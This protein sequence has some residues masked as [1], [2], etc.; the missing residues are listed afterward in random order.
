MRS[1]GENVRD[2]D[3]YNCGGVSTTSP[4]PGA[5]EAKALLWHKLECDANFKK[6]SP[7]ARKGEI[8]FF[9]KMLE[10]SDLIRLN[11]NFKRAKLIKSINEY[12]R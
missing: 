5:L 11:V 12:L 1:E 3:G 6:F 4:A 9:I 7:Y 2:R 10:M 8:E